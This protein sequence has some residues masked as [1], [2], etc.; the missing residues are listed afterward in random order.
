[1]EKV[2][3][4]SIILARSLCAGANVVL[5]P[6]SSPSRQTS[7]LEFTNVVSAGCTVQTRLS[8]AVV[9]VDL[10]EST[11]VTLSALASELVV[12]INAHLCSLGVAWVAQAL[13]NLQF[14]LKT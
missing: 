8:S 14:T 10:A 9:N 2:N 12:L 1:L 7:A 4:L 13:I 3:A 6:K 5:A 11:G